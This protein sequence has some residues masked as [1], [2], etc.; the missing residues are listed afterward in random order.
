MKIAPSLTIEHKPKWTIKDYQLL[1]FNMLIKFGDAVEIYLL[2]VITQ[3]VAYELNLSKI[4][5]ECWL[6]C[7]LPRP[8]L[9]NK[10]MRG[11]KIKR[12]EVKFIS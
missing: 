3:K 8:C 5:V 6:Y 9:V 12:R 4:Q 7:G 11:M 2:G 10:D 1:V